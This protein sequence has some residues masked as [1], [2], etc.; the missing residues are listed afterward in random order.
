MGKEKENPLEGVLKDIISGI[1]KKGGLT[2]EDV[3]SAWESAVGEKAAKHSRPRTLRGSRLIV[4]V[5][6]SSWLY[7][8]TVQKKEILKK[9]GEILKSNKLKDI[10]L[11]IGELG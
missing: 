11:R 10:T 7:E 9:L 8:L 5:D 3:R 2:E 6:D 1:S 4:H